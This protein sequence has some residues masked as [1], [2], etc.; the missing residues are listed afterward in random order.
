M[1]IICNWN[2]ILAPYGHAKL[3]QELP[4][5][6]DQQPS[7]DVDPFDE[8]ILYRHN[9]P[10]LIVLA[11]LRAWLRPQCSAVEGKLDWR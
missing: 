7:R 11:A 10:E 6:T 1:R 8:S 5:Y 4:M 9:G 2:E 3:F